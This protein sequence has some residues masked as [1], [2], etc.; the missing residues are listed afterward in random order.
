LFDD[1]DADP[2]FDPVNWTSP[3]IGY[4]EVDSIFFEHLSSGDEYGEEVI[5]CRGKHSTQL[6]FFTDP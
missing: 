4:F 2:K 1:G 6:K 3:F 5:D